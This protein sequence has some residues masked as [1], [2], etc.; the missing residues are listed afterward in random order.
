MGER[1]GGGGDGGSGALPSPTATPSATAAASADSPSAPTPAD[2]VSGSARSASPFP[3]LGDD[4]STLDSTMSDDSAD[5]VTWRASHLDATSRAQGGGASSS[6]ALLAAVSPSSSS[7]FVGLHGSGASTIYGPYR[8][9][10]T[11]PRAIPFRPL[12]YLGDVDG[13]L[14][15]SPSDPNQSANLRRAALLRSLQIRTL[16]RSPA[17]G[18]G[19]AIT[20]QSVPGVTYA[21]SLE[22]HSP[23][24][25]PQTMHALRSISS[26]SSRSAH[27][28]SGPPLLLSLAVPAAFRCRRA[29]SPSPPLSSSVRP[30]ANLLAMTTSPLEAGE[31]CRSSEVAVTTPVLGGSFSGPEMSLSQPNGLSQS[32]TEESASCTS[33]AHDEAM[34]SGAGVGSASASVDVG[35]G[36]RGFP[37]YLGGLATGPQ[38]PPAPLPRPLP[39]LQLLP[40]PPPATDQ[41]LQAVPARRDKRSLQRTSLDLL[42]ERYV[43]GNSDPLCRPQL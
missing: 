36:W 33:P 39:P 35:W 4:L 17:S 23:Q 42:A 21:D 14:P 34:S 12:P 16:P 13:R 38:V 6:T 15:P 37:L 20:S 29:T 3:S 27:G 18:T 9:G 5:S 25:L 19:I 2:N 41:D 40:P 22:R 43:Q 1:A 28:C 10:V 30:D 24:E 31:R 32:S 11:V 26:D 8:S 7:P